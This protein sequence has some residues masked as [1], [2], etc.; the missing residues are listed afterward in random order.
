MSVFVDKV[1]LRLHDP[2][3][4]KTLVA[5]AAD[6]SFET[7][8]ALFA[9][10]Y[11][12]PAASL[13]AVKSVEVRGSELE[14]PVF[15]PE[16]RTGTWT[17]T[18]P[19][20]ERTDVVYEGTN[21]MK[22][23]WIDAVSHLSVTV[24][25]NVDSGELETITAASIDDFTSLAQFKAKFRFFDLDA[26][27]EEHGI[28]TAADLKRL[29]HYLLAELKL[30]APPAFDPNDP[31]N[32]RRFDLDLAILVRDTVDLAEALRDAKL[33]VALLEHAVAFRRESEEAEVR[34]PFAPVVVFPDDALP[35]GVTADELK[36]F[37]AAERV[38]ALL[39]PP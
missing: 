23:Q 34:T 30:K 36:T 22:P 37:F 11:S 21:G 20:H 31:A 16:R 39:T 17:K 15:V 24:V 35:A 26:F 25:L 1:L 14:R 6:A 9:A 10:V 12:F 2:A 29:A 13:A 33:T 38:M 32:E 8:K 27:M 4:V 3:K 28:T 19:G 18:I 5:P 7:I